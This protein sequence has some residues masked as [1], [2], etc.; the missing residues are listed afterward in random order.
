MHQRP[1]TLTVLTGCFLSLLNPAPPSSGM[2]PVSQESRVQ[3]HFDPT[4][5]RLDA[6]KAEPAATEPCYDIGQSAEG[7]D[8]AEVDTSSAS[9][10]CLEPCGRSGWH[11]DRG[12]NRDE[13]GPHPF[14]LEKA[15]NQKRIERERAGILALEQRRQGTTQDPIGGKRRQWRSGS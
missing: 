8:I 7:A 2:C 11:L 14:A 1:S 9:H 10:Q 4:S 5:P 13:W 15:R 3:S 12:E 6:R